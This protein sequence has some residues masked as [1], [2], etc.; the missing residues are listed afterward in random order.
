MTGSFFDRLAHSREV[1]TE[2][3]L[4]LVLGMGKGF[5]WYRLPSQQRL[6]KVVGNAGELA[7]A[8]PLD[9]RLRVLPENEP[10]VECVFAYARDEFMNHAVK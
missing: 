5:R 10:M 2:A 3:L 4:F 8:Q 6:L 7:P 1:K 9:N